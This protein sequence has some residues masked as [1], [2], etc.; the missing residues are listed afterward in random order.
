MADHAGDA[1]AALRAG[2]DAHHLQRFA[3]VD[4]R[5]VGQDIAAGLGRR[6][7]VAGD[8]AVVTGHRVVVGTLDE[9]VQARHGL[10]ADGVTHDVG[11]TLAQGLACGAQGLHQ[12]VG[13]I[14]QVL[15]A[16]V[17]IEDQGAVAAH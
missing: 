11:E 12:R 7:L 2:A 14:Q 8:V 6:G 13:V 15:V 5:V 3:C 10:G 1:A 16:A 17:G 9:D 4:V